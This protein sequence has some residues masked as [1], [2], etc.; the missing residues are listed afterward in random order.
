LTMGGGPGTSGI[1]NPLSAQGPCIVVENGTTPTPNRWTEHFNLLALDHPIG[2]G[3]SYG[4]KVNNSRTAAL[5][6]YDFLQKFFCLYPDLAQ[7]QL[8]LSGGSYGAMYVPHI[9]TVIHEQNI[10]LTAGKGKGGSVHFNFESMMISNPISDATSHF[11]WLLQTRCYNADI[12]N[13]STCAGMFKL[14]PTCLDSIQLA[15]QA[16]EWSMERR[17]AAQGICQPLMEGDAHGTVL[18]DIRKKAKPLGSLPPSFTWLETFFRRP[19]IKFAL[20]I[21]HHL[22]FSVLS[23]EVNIEF[24]RMG[25]VCVIKPAYLLHE[26]LLKAG[27]RLLRKL[28]M[29]LAPVQLSYSNQIVLR[30]TNIE[31]TVPR[32]PGDW[33][34]SI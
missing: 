8:V 21:P 26:P 14:L 23:D 24:R 33:P 34:D 16:P 10:A 27:M 2:A 20:N 9:A 11:T 19:E 15:Q 3:F 13:T 22:N 31:F 5:D 28:Y 17:V 25:R 12:Y 29:S 1:S 30:R 6:V 7:N 4:P 18:E 32:P